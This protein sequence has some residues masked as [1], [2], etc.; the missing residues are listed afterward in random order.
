M[1]ASNCQKPVWTGGIH[2]AAALVLSAI[3]T[4]TTAAAQEMPAIILGSQPYPGEASIFVA[5]AKGFF[6]QAGVRV[7]DRRLPSGRLTLDAMLSGSLD[8]ATPVETGP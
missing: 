1:I 5:E 7:T 2:I 6:D 4:M 8:I 3:G